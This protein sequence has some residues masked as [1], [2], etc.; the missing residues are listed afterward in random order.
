MTQV[1]LGEQLCTQGKSHYFSYDV[2]ITD[3]S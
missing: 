1:N 3:C 2:Q